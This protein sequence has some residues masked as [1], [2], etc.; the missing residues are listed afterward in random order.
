MLQRRV[1]VFAMTSVPV[2][3]RFF[4]KKGLFSIPF[5]GTH[6]RRAGKTRRLL[7]QRPTAYRRFERDQVNALWQGDALVGPWLPD[8]GQPGHDEVA[9]LVDQD[10]PNEDDQQN[11][12]SPAPEKD[13]VQAHR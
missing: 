10:Q 2:Q 7:A 4:A 12:N 11:G 1:M 5:L 6:L 9:Q 8:P 3:I 13:P